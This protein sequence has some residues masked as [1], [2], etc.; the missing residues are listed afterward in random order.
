[1]VKATGVCKLCGDT[2]KL[3]KSHGIPKALFRTAIGGGPGLHLVTNSH[4]ERNQC[5]GEYDKLLCR[6]CENALSLHDQFG[7]RFI[8]GEIGERMAELDG[9]AIPPEFAL[10]EGIDVRRLKR[11]HS[12]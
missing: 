1:M 8:R 12:R 9:S 2:T 3:C 4:L 5:G 11:G 10:I 7:I 6:R